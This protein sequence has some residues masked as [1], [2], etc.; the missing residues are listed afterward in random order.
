M[1]ILSRTVTNVIYFCVDFSV[2]SDGGKDEICAE[3]QVGVGE[4]GGSV[5]LSSEGIKMSAG[6]FDTTT[7][8]RR[9]RSVGGEYL[10]EPG[11]YL[12]SYY[13][14]ATVGVLC[15]SS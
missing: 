7:S 3:Q 11:R 4:Y 15:Y 8:R 1:I 14:P 6:G 2:G 12:P 13:N 5:S 9:K 10:M